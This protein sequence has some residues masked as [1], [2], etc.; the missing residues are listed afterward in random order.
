[1]ERFRNTWVALLGGALLVTLSVSAA[2]GAG[3]SGTEDGTR[4][5]TIAGF[6]HTLVFGSDEEEEPTTVEE[7]DPATDP[8][9]C[10]VVEECD[11]VTGPDEC[12][13]VEEEC[14][15]ETDADACE[16][17]DEEQAEEED[18]D[19]ESDS[20]GACVSAVAHD[21]D[22]ENDPEDADYANHGERVS[23]AARVLC[24]DDADGDEEPIEEEQTDEEDEE[25]DSHGA[26][27][28]AVAHDKDGE[29][30]PEDA[31]YRNHGERVSHAARVLC[32][33]DGDSED[34][35]EESD[36]ETTSSEDEDGGKGK[37]EWAGNGKPESAGKGGHRGG[38]RP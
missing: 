18:G 23:E 16:V 25:S 29:N 38:G 26:C 7:C 35:A 2:F 24:W 30:D 10:E 17:D 31:E 3:P 13:P 33:E 5:Q 4:G 1:M 6:V 37:P 14:D 15:P 11:P 28:S 22:G 32:R 27:V 21:K 36:S 19:E 20:H 9:G 12:E 34:A 8:D